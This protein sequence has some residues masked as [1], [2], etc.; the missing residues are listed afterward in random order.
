MVIPSRLC[1]HTW[2]LILTVSL[3]SLRAAQIIK[4]TSECACLSHGARTLGNI[5]GS[6]SL[7]FW[8]FSYSLSPGY[9][10]LSN[11]STNTFYHIVPIP[12]PENYALKILKLGLS[13]FKL[14]QVF[15]PSKRKTDQ[16]STLPVGYDWCGESWGWN[17][18]PCTCCASTLLWFSISR[19][20]TM[21]SKIQHCC[22]R[23]TVAP[24]T[25]YQWIADYIPP[26]F[27][28][29]LDSSTTK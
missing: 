14:Y 27:F 5:P 15:C 4:L 11:Y 2:Q 23:D 29:K 28:S 20:Y 9:Q 7:S 13:S 26:T 1:K 18:G 22:L 19:F 6:C 24:V 10:E 8:S 3:V 16:C 21:T 12:E 25:S 17:S